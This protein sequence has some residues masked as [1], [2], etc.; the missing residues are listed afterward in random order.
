MGTTILLKNGNIQPRTRATITADFTIKQN[1]RQEFPG[2][3][4]VSSRLLASV[5]ALPFFAVPT[6]YD[7]HDL[8]TGLAS[9]MMRTG[10][11]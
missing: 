1:S 6:R 3:L 4:C 7:S 11:I 2:E 5:D 8:N 10:S 9:N